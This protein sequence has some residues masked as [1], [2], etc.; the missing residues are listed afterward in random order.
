[1]NEN[2]PDVFN[3][4]EDIE[5]WEIAV[6]IFELIEEMYDSYKLIE[7]EPNPGTLLHELN[8]K[9]NDGSYPSNH[10]YISVHSFIE[11]LV[12]LESMMKESKSGSRYYS[13]YSVG[14]LARSALISSCRVIY[15]LLAEDIP[16][17]MDKIHVHNAKNWFRFTQEAS[18]FEE[19]SSLR[20]PFALPENQK[21]KSDVHESDMNKE[22]FE[23][24]M[25]RV[26]SK[27][28]HELLGNTFGEHLTWMWQSWSGYTHSQSWPILLPNPCRE[29]NVSYMPGYWI[30]DFRNLVC[31]CKI[32]LDLYLQALTKDEI[33]GY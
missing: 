12:L 9:Y 29:L 14:P 13:P 32:A 33:N 30:A 5:G 18:Q 8:L 28:P 7:P 16:H 15:V 23:Y 26:R 25:D 22:S 1:M 27:Y 31:V 6:S 21:G 24:I 2:Q 19:L 10:L 3:L 17:N 4:R 20:F 11:N